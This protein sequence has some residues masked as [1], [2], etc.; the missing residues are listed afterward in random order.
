MLERYMEER[1]DPATKKRLKK[2]YKAMDK[3]ELQD[4][5]DYCEQE[6]FVTDMT[7]KCTEL[8]NQICD[9]DE[10]LEFAVS[11]G[12][13]EFLTKA[14]EMC[15]AFGYNQPNV[16]AAR[17]LLTRIVRVKEEAAVAVQYGIEDQIRAVVTAAKEVHTVNPD[18]AMLQTWLQ[19]DRE[20]FLG[21]LYAKAKA[22]D[23]ADH[24]N[25]AVRIAIELKDIFVAKRKR[26]LDINAYEN[27]KDPTAWAKEA[28]IFAFNKKK[29][30]EGMLVFQKNSLH[31]PMTTNVGG[32]A[33][34]REL[35]AINKAARDNFEVL[36]KFMG[37]AKTV[38]MPQR[39]DE[40]F[41]SCAQ[42]KGK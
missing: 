13:E 30:M 28:G 34:G 16:Q 39:L 37:Q 31:A 24:A 20:E 2:A 19:M 10:A 6:G 17:R 11:K 5:L 8:L 23:D 35:K 26:S 4:V 12:S 21:I 1:M 38:R 32:G 18:I 15:D 41:L 40:C 14:L 7:R 36:K 42:H 27:L 3:H 22:S 29:I 33:T 9:A 25:R